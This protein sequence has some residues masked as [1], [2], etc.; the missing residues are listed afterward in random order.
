MVSNNC[1]IRAQAWDYFFFIYDERV[2]VLAQAQ[3]MVK[4]LLWR[5]ALIF[6]AQP[7]PFSRQRQ[8][9]SH[10]DRQSEKRRSAVGNKRQRHALGG[11]QAHRRGQIDDRLQTEFD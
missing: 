3:L 4:M 8:Q 11:D 9:H 6:L 10:P 1:G 5:E 2:L 7:E